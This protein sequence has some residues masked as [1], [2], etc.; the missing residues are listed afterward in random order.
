MSPGRLAA[1]LALVLMLPL[2]T[3]VPAL[4][5]LAMVTAVW[6]AL[7]AYELIWWREARAASRSLLS[8]IRVFE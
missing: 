4:A 5:T 6:V 3:F 7:H 1:A 8:C 2:A